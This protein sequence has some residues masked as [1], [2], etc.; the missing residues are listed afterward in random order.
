MR[1]DIDIDDLL[2]FKAMRITKLKTKRAA[3]EA[4]LR[5]L[6]QTR[7]QS[8]IRRPRGKTQWDADL[9]GSRLGQS[10]G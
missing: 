10:K 3:I 7:A 8:S 5:L 4:G 1:L 9:D 2:M 6:I